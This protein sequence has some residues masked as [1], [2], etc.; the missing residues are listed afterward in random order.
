MGACASLAGVNSP[1][2][3]G[4]QV[5]NWLLTTV[6][7]TRELSSGRWLRSAW[8]KVVPRLQELDGKEIKS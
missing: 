1:M 6:M 5:T 2:H 7:G 8:S 4:R 3:E